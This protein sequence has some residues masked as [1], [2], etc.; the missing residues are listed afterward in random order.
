M[1]KAIIF[2]GGGAPLS[3]PHSL[4]EEGDI[5][6]AADSGYDTAKFF[7][8]PVDLV[9]GDL[10]STKFFEEINRLAFKKSP[11]DKDESDTE[12]AIKE[13]ISLGFNEYILI[14]GG[15]YR[16]DHLFSLYGLFARYKPPIWWHTKYESLRRVCS[17]DRFSD[18]SIGQTV[19][20][21]PIRFN[22]TVIVTAK[23]LAWP[24]NQFPLSFDNIS[25]SNRVT[26]SPLEVFV[27]NKATLFVGFPVAPKHL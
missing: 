13:S 7:N 19:S 24:L 9:I 5:I 15:G 6:I 20:F 10:D 2:T 12:L 14:G 27:A 25:L 23:Q 11:M 18:V 4:Y 3:L 17:F 8:I 16:M 26:D 22:E 1:S 21:I